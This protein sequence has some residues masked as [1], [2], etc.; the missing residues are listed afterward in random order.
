MA[1]AKWSAK[2]EHISACNCN[3]GCPCS[4]DA[5][6]TYGTCEASTAT[7]IVKGKYGRTTLD[8]LMFVVV[9]KWPGPL[10]EKHGRA[11]VFLDERAKGEK[12]EALE[13]IASGKAG[14]PWGIFMST[15]TDG[16]AVRQARIDFKFAGKKSRFGVANAT[17]VALRAIRN[18]VDGSEHFVTGVLP[19]GLLTRR[20]DFFASETFWVKA[21]GLEFAYPQRNALTFS[22]VW[23]GP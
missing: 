17:E 2:V 21:D 1:S 10:H 5:P 6:P 8:G 11:V 22:A 16:V 3:F 4:F 13:A 9:A 19:T 18:P 20:E 23:K 7:R 15:A 14:G 12:R